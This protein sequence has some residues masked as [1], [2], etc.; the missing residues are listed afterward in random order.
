MKIG[1]MIFTEELVTGVRSRELV[2]E[3]LLGQKWKKKNACLRGRLECERKLE[4]LVE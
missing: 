3:K 2:R 1:K 4:I